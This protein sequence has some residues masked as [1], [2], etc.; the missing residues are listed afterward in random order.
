MNWVLPGGLLALA[1]LVIAYLTYRFR[2]IARLRQTM[3]RPFTRLSHAC[4]S[5]AASC[6]QAYEK[7]GAWSETYVVVRLVYLTV[8][9]LVFLGDY[10]PRD[11]QRDAHN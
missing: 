4:D 8:A 9:L 6:K 11:A 2:A 5:A 7:S 10:S 3:A 1:L